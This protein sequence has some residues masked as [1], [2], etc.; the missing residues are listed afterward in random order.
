MRESSAA[1]SM[2]ESAT[3]LALAAAAAAPDGE[4]GGVPGIGQERE[5]ARL[6]RG[7]GGEGGEALTRGWSRGSSGSRSG[8]KLSLLLP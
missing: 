5:G 7:V 4:P 6:G 3:V 8:E 2:P 1:S